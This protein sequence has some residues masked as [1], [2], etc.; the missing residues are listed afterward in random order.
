MNA[1]TIG[2]CKLVPEATIPR[3]AH[4]DDLGLDLHALESVILEPGVVTKVRTGI[5]CQFPPWCGGLIRDRSGVATKKG[6]FVVA[7][8]IDPQYTGEIIVAFQNFTD[9]LVTFN[10]GDRIA[11]MIVMPVI[12]VDVEEITDDM[13]QETLR[14]INGFGS[15]GQ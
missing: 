1:L 10:A 9:Q 5:A 12:P 11:Q 2:F 3:K 7:G 6:V 13:L 8:V 15:T 14:G 4:D